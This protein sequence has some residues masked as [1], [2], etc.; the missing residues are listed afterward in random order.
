MGCQ[1]MGISTKTDFRRLDR[2]LLHE[3]GDYGVFSYDNATG[4]FSSTFQLG[5]PGE[6]MPCFY[7]ASFDKSKNSLKVDGNIHLGNL[8]RKNRYNGV[9]YLGKIISDEL[10]LGKR[11]GQA[12]STGEFS[13]EF[14]FESDDKLCIFDTCCFVNMYAINRLLDDGYDLQYRPRMFSEKMELDSS[15]RPNFIG[16]DPQD[17]SISRGQ[18]LGARGIIARGKDK[19]GDKLVKF[20]VVFFRMDIIRD[21]ETA[22]YFSNSERLSQDMLLSLRYIESGN[23]IRI[24][25]I[26]TFHQNVYRRTPDIILDVL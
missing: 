24:Y 14:T 10:I 19:G 20:N 8:T 4:K 15:V 26:T 16:K 22:S 3:L 12:D 2:N 25:E 6:M 21:S 17:N 5:G 7:N 18:V 9:L 1:L 13:I 11:I 23:T